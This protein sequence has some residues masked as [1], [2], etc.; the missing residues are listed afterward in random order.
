MQT[1]KINT[2]YTYAIT[3][4]LLGSSNEIPTTVHASYLLSGY[5]SLIEKGNDR[6]NDKM[7]VYLNEKCF[8]AIGDYE[9]L[10]KAFNE[11]SQLISWKP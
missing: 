10:R 6:L 4:F 1:E 9:E 5:V 7:H 8:E 11:F 2:G 3:G